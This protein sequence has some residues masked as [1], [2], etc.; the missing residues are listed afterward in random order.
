MTRHAELGASRAERW[1]HCP[2][3]VRMARDLPDADTPYAAE[4]R[5]AHALAEEWLRVWPAEPAP[6]P[7]ANE[8]GVL[9]P[10]PPGMHE[11]VR[12]YVEYVRALVSRDVGVRLSVEVTFD[13]AALSPPRPMFG[14]ADAVV[15]GGRRLDVIDLK[16]GQGVVVEARGNAQLLYYVLGALVASW[17]EQNEGR[18]FSDPLSPLEVLE[19]ALA[20]FDDIW[21]H[22]VQPRAPHADG[23][24]RTAQVSHQEVREYAAHLMLRAGA[25]LDPSAP[26]HAGAWCK[27]CPA[28]AFCPEL[29]SRSLAIAR[30]EFSNSPPPVETLP[31]EVAADVLA[32]AEML[33][34]WLAAVRRRVE[35]EL[36]AGRPVPGWKLVTKRP[37]RVWNNPDALLEWYKARG[38]L[39]PDLYV[40]EL[41]S[42][43]QVEQV[44]GKKNLPPELYSLV[45]SG[46]ALAPEHDRRP[47]A[48]V[49][50]Q[51]DFT[52]LPPAAAE[53]SAEE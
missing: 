37:R 3:S 33:E 9:V 10:Q 49:G 44:V 52:A 11:H 26:L 12:A 46:L 15:T 25:T 32:K 35:A 4:G 50:P 38:G 19:S 34:H 7:Y 5:A 30:A 20:R 51:K 29:K 16:Y 48:Q 39:M 41:K 42:P 14:T 53:T 43:A 23:P 1:T 27:F 21:V 13:L 45:S 40:Q 6:R 28:A 18:T 31:I 22:V 8:R 17:W 36:E 24:V 2:G 47:A